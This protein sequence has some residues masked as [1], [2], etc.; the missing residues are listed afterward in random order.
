[1]SAADK[2]LQD[3]HDDTGATAFFAP[4]ANLAPTVTTPFTD[5]ATFYLDMCSATATA[6]EKR[7]AD[8]LIT[9][10]PNAAAVKFMA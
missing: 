8:A 3:C 6:G 4:T 9:P 2:H 7:A 10:E 1:M 5:T